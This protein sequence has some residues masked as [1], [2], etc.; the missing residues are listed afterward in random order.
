MSE[1][2]VYP[3]HLVMHRN[4]YKDTLFDVEGNVLV[5]ESG[6]KLN[7]FR[8]EMKDMM[9]DKKVRC[10]HYMTKEPSYIYFVVNQQQADHFQYCRDNG[11]PFQ[12]THFHVYPDD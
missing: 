12:G 4:R 5:G 11:S 7:V 8:E 1:P 10:I 6:L 3:I 2:E 9:I